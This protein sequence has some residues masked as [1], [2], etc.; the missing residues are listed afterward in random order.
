MRFNTPAPRRG[1]GA[2]VG[3]YAFGDS[4]AAARRLGLLAEL[5][6]PAP[7]PFLERFA[8]R[9]IDL[10]CG[11]GH[12]TRLLAS[13]L[14]PRRLGVAAPAHLR[15]RYPA[16]SS[17]MISSHRSRQAAQMAT[18]PP[19]VTRP[20]PGDHVPQKLQLRPG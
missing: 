18:D 9:P 14:A 11:P 13:V 16:C 5:F 20:S 15:A 10:A 8:G 12:T 19:L 17:A 7:R 4:A 1:P 6:E 2:A 3:G